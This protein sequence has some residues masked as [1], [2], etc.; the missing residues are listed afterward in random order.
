MGDFASIKAK[1]ERFQRVS[2]K[3]ME[4]E[5]ESWYKNNIRLGGEQMANGLVKPFFPRKKNYGHPMLNE[6]GA[7]LESI[8]VIFTR[9]KMV[10]SHD[11]QNY[12]GKRDYGKIHNKY[13]TKTKMG[14]TQ[15]VKIVRPFMRDSRPLADHVE[16]KIGQMIENI[17]I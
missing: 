10:V 9:G 2:P 8:K 17:F 15:I 3:V 13:G 7:L 4:N 5:V 11:V 6:T 16:K 14:K 1:I 12:R